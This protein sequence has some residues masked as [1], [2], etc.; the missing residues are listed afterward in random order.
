L[1]SSKTHNEVWASIRKKGNAGAGAA[2]GAVTSMT[3]RGV[4]PQY[5]GYATAALTP[6]IANKT[7]YPRSHM[8]KPGDAETASRGKEGENRPPGTPTGRQSVKY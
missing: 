1:S 3:A 8:G 6:T 4:L 5:S 2:P 7:S